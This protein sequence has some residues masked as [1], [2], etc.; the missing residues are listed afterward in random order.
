MMIEIALREIV[1]YFGANPVLTGVTFEV[2]QGERIALLGKNGSGKTTLLRIVSGEEEPDSGVKAVR[3]GAKLG[4]LKQIPELTA[5]ATVKTIL[6][7][8]FQEILAEKAEMDQIEAGLNGNTPDALLIKYGKLQEQYETRGGYRIDGEVGRIV[9]GLRI[10]D[11]L[12]RDFN[13]LS[14]GEKTRVMLGRMMLQAPEVL[15]LDEPTNHL[16][17]FSLEWLEDYLREYRGTI[18]VTSHDRYFLNRV[19]N[20]VVELEAGKAVLYKGNFTYYVSEKEARLQQQL[21]RYQDQQKQIRQLQEAAQRLHDWAKRADNSKMHRQAFSIEKRLERIEKIDRPKREANLKAEFSKLSFSG[22]EVITIRALRKSFGDKSVLDNLDLQIYQGERVGIL[23]KNGSGKSTLFKILAGELEPDR[24]EAKLGRSICYAYLP[25]TIVFTQPS[26][27]ILETVRFELRIGEETARRLLAS[28]KFKNEE[29]LKQVQTLSGGEKSR[30][31]ICLLMQN[32]LNLLLLDEPT[33]HL[34]LASREWLEEALEH[35]SGT[36]VFISHD[37][38]FINKFAT[39]LVEL[40]DGRLTGLYGNY[41]EYREQRLD[42]KETEKR[43]S[44]KTRRVPTAPKPKP[45]VKPDYEQLISDC[46]LELRQLAREMEDFSHE[47]VRL[48]ELYSSQLLLEEKVAR[49]YEEW[50]AAED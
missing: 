3:K 46:E 42:F 9:R 39:R 45:E 7:S 20:R 44:G 36:M 41:Q 49:L 5:D 33:N 23:G 48:E 13:K 14:G 18:L 8:V 17:L 24:G 30:L 47:S 25:Q 38:Y 29:L 15:M 35:F 2:R 50:E 31:K 37:R 19:V 6:Y 1:K 22:K 32:E 40:K 27:N 26:R 16:D 21:H 12:D 28:Y 43:R 34:D 11:L 4:F 10:D